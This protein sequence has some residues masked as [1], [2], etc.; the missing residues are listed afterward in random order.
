MKPTTDYEI[1]IDQLINLIKEKEKNIANLKAENDM[2]RNIIALIPGNI[3]W[4]DKEGYYLGC[5][6]NVA[7]IL[8]LSSPEEIIGKQNTELL[9]AKLGALADQI[10]NEVNVS[11]KEIYVEENGLNINLEP[12]IYLTKKLPLFDDTR[13]MIGILGVSFDITE[14]K[15]IEEDLKIAKENAEA[16]NR[17]KS[18]FLAV[19]N[20]ELRTPLTS[21]VGL[22]DFLKQ[23]DLPLEE[24]KNIIDAIDNCTQHLLSLVNEVLDFSRLE[25]GKYN[26]RMDPVSLNAILY[27]VYGITKTL[28]KKKGLE[29][30]IESGPNV[31]KTILTDSRVLRQI[32]INLVSN[33]IKFTEK[34]HVTIRLN[35]LEQNHHKTKLEITVVDTG[36][37]IPSNKIKLIFEP[38]QQLEDAYTRQSSRAGTGLGLTIVE[39]LAALID[40]VISVESEPG[41]GSTFSIISEFE[42]PD[43][44]GTAGP[45]V[46][47]IEK[48]RKKRRKKNT[49][50]KGVMYSNSI[51]QKPN[52]LLVEDDPIVQYVHKKMLTDLG[53]EVCTASHGHEAITTLNN[54]DIVFVDI[55][56]PDI[57]GFEVIKSIRQHNHTSKIPIIAL[58]VYTGKE[59][60]SACLKAGANEFASKPI[61]QN[62]LKKLLLRYLKNPEC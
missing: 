4:K 25:S 43:N 24:E 1:L 14:R 27:E 8:G 28:A 46:L 51:T 45:H 23:G 50:A 54:H 6:Y 55:N 58:T 17:A 11:G 10:D 12:A 33:A 18:Q 53:C 48:L 13:K 15:K 61:S 40:A 35:T 29:L 19:V 21:I 39:K 26:I 52:V 3:Y 36:L 37:G 60:K 2:L 32:L 22:I 62:H 38:F 9:D 34:G 42:T 47:V 44:D 16:S 5:N 20:H 41:R 7:Q 57:S 56:L 49:C 59:E 30:R 31:P